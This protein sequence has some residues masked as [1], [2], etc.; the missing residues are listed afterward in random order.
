MK[1]MKKMCYAYRNTRDNNKR[2][3][4]IAS[5]DQ[6]KIISKT[7]GE[8]NERGLKRRVGGKERRG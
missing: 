8:K 7:C 3:L 6:T 4:K 1:L 2:K 5:C